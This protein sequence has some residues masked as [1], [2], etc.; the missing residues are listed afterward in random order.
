MSAQR[1]G[2]GLRVEALVRREV[3]ELGAGQKKVPKMEPR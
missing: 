3:S 2:H 1:A